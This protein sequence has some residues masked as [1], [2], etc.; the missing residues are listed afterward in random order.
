MTHTLMPLSFELVELNQNKYKMKATLEVIQQ[1]HH[2]D[3]S[4]VVIGQCKSLIESFSKS[5]LDEFEANYE[6]NLAI[7]KLAKKAVQELGVGNSTVKP[8]KTKEA[9]LK[10]VTSFSQSIET[11]A[12]GIGELRN[13]FC[14]LAHG[15]S[16]YQSKLDMSYA[17]FIANQTDSLVWFMHELRLRALAP[18]DDII[19]K[20]KGHDD[21][22]DDIYES[23]D[24][25]G[26]TYLPSEILWHV[27]PKKYHT[28]LLESKE[29]QEQNVD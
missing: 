9:Y 22:L 1:A 16:V 20:D 7:G 13:D 2:D 27:N 25:F 4:G 3:E 18:K 15:R 12:K 19:V 24:I 11:A 5:I 29:E 28:S 26:D 10:L 23:V 14:P 17:V 6:S 8:N 21:L